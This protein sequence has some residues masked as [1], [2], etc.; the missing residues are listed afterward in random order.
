MNENLSL[1]LTEKR[2]EGLYCEALHLNAGM[3]SGSAE[4]SGMLNEQDHS[5][6]VFIALVPHPGHRGT[7]MHQVTPEMGPPQPRKEQN[8]HRMTEELA[9][10]H[11]QPTISPLLLY[12]ISLI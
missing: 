4:G 5:H 7:P 2:C 12:W 3:T 11:D 10:H 9:P 6:S 8:R 1:N